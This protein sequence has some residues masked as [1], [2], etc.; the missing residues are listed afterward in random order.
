MLKNKKVNLAI[1]FFIAVAL[2]AFV[3]YAVD[4][5]QKNT[6]K[7]VPVKLLN[8]EQAEAR[9]LTAVNE[10]NITVDVDVEAARSVLSN[11]DTDDITVTADVGDCVEGDNTVATDISFRKAAK[12]SNDMTITVHIGFERIV[13]EEKPVGVIYKTKGDR[14][15]EAT[16]DEDM[17]VA[18]TG[19]KSV[20]SKVAKVVAIITDED[21]EG[22]D[23]QKEMALHAV[24]DKDKL[25]DDVTLSQN[26]AFVTIKAYSQK[27]VMLHVRTSGTPA[28]GY[29]KV[30][31]EAPGSVTIMGKEEDI[32]GIDSLAA[33]MIDITDATETKKVD[34]AFNLPEGVKLVPDQSL[35]AVVYI[36]KEGTIQTT[37]NIDSDLMTF[38]N[39]GS[40]LKVGE[41]SDVK[42]TG[43]GIKKGEISVTVDL[44]GLDAGTHKVK[45]KVKTKEG[46]ITE[47]SKTVK[48]ILE[49]E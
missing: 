4:P 1:S 41:C 17:N 27:T 9:G 8:L 10:Q 7:D 48:V 31:V 38:E 12:V 30:S 49:R 39:L 40:G 22:S 20:V 11:M 13:S 6:I 5:V 23:G 15:K 36:Y 3:I 16:I 14:V 47:Y 37:F 35:K 46:E 18:V 29:K 24:D 21:M 42:V 19:A 32:E 26:T 2:W 34:L 44:D 25:I 33:K 43:M 28:A 45:V